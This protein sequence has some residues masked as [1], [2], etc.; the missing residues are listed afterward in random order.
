M[1]IRIVLISDTHTYHDEVNVPDG[2]LLIHAGDATARGN[3]DEVSRFAQWFN[4]LPHRHKIFVAGNHDWLYEKRPSLADTLVPSL[5]DKSIE[6]EGLKIHGSSWQ[7]EFFNWAF[8]LPRGRSLAEKWA[9]IPD[10][11]DILITHGPPHGILDETIDG[12]F[13]GCRDLL[14]AVKRV[15]PKIHVFG[16]IH[17]G[18]GTVEINGTRFVNASI[19]DEQYRAI[20]APVVIDL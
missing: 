1:S 13:V 17:N 4:A 8:N 7:P 6:I 11:I 12:R 10:D 5:H 16:H 2:D 20:N 15:K 19:C 9:L 3:I 18:Y 14:K